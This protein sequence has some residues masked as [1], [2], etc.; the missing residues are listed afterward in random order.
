MDSVGVLIVEVDALLPLAYIFTIMVAF[1]GV[2]IFLSVVAFQK[3]V[4][5]EYIKWWGKRVKKYKFG[6]ASSNINSS[7]SSTLPKV[8]LPTFPFYIRNKMLF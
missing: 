6:T 3:S 4:R 2:I 8:D 7:V 1:Q 5:D